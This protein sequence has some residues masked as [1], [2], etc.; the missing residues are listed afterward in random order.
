MMFRRQRPA[1][2][3]ALPAEPLTN[4]RIGWLMAVAACA[5]VPHGSHLPGWLI[6]AAFWGIFGCVSPFIQG[7][8]QTIDATHQTRVSRTTAGHAHTNHL[9]NNS[10]HPSGVLIGHFIQSRARLRQSLSNRLKH[11]RQ[12]RCGCLCNP[13]AHAIY[14]ASQPIGLICLRRGQHARTGR[15]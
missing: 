4:T 6:Y 15:S 3:P 13:L 8:R 11:L 9:G 12:W 14:R 1:V 2:A 5:L 7:S 10:D